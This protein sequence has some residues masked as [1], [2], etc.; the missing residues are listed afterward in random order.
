MDVSLK[1]QTNI[2]SRNSVTCIHTRKLLQMVDAENTDQ[3]I[4]FFKKHAKTC[5]DC[6]KKLKEIEKS[7]VKFEFFIPKPKAIAEIKQEFDSELTQLLENLGYSKQSIEKQKRVEIVEK[8]KAVVRDIE[9]VLN[10]KKI[11]ATI[12]I[13]T[14]SSVALLNLLLK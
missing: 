11:I 7:L 13:V 6:Q 1:N 2:L 4:V 12:L 10:D 9:L 8:I 5:N 3:R 14:V